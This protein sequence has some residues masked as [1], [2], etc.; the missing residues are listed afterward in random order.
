ME[1]YRRDANSNVDVRLFPN[2]SLLF[3]LIRLFFFVRG[4]KCSVIVPASFEFGYNANDDRRHDSEAD[5]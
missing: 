5:E 1:D 3:L 2:L 4:R